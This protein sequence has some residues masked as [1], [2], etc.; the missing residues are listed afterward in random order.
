MQQHKI[1]WRQFEIPGKGEL[2]LNTRQ[3]GRAEKKIR[4]V[5]FPEIWYNCKMNSKKE[6][7]MKKIFVLSMV[8]LFGVSM[9]LHAAGEKKRTI[10]FTGVGVAGS[11]LGGLFLDIGAEKRFF[12]NFYGQFLF[13]YYFNPFDTPT[14]ADSY[15][16]GLNFY[17]VYKIPVSGN[18]H[19][20]LKGGFHFSTLYRERANSTISNR[21]DSGLAWGGGIEYHLSK[22][23]YFRGG[24]TWKWAY[25]HDDKNFKWTK[26]YGGLVFHVK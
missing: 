1:Y 13:D 8:I 19:F 16:Y 6:M 3:E 20:F 9:V 11:D 7:K 26:I 22:L 25:D 17:G 15:A 18:I 4:R 5:L 23:I 24:V 12:K 14:I 2:H 21:K 10:L